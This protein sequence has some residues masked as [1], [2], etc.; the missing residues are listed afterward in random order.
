MDIARGLQNVPARPEGSCVAFGAFDG[1]HLGHQRLLLRTARSAEGSN[2]RSAAL[3]FEPHPAK[4]LHPDRE[5][6]LLTDLDEKA[7]LIERLGIDLL[8]VADFDEAMAFM[9]AEEFLVEVLKETLGARCLVVG[10]QVSF[11]CGALG[12]ILF[13]E[14]QAPRHEIALEVVQTVASG[15][16]PASSTAIRRLLMDGAVEKASRLLGRPYRLT[17]TIVKG[18]GRGH[19]LAFPTANLKVQ[20]EKLWPRDGVYAGWAEIRGS[21]LPAVINVGPRPTFRDS[22]RVVEAHILDFEHDLYGMT[23]AV[24]FVSRLRDERQF[25]SSGE[26]R[27]QIERDCEA[28]CALLTAAS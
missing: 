19:Q 13:L 9:S 6:A 2:L 25:S 20:S 8:V 24:E 15:A 28:A 10:P 4:I 14:Q 22:S 18:A 16:I 12:D 1:V 11:G 27:S 5:L 26:L 3:T 23:L 21:L 17:G 7:A